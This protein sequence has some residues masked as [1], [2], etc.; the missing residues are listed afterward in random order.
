MYFVPEVMLVAPVN[1]LGF[2]AKLCRSAVKGREERDAR[3]DCSTACT[4]GDHTP[5]LYKLRDLDDRAADT[6]MFEL[7]AEIGSL[8]QFVRKIVSVAPRQSCHT[9]LEP[10]SLAGV[11]GDIRHAPPITRLGEPKRR[12]G[13]PS[14]HPAGDL[15]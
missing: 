2:V 12:S 10:V 13:A 11:L 6:T 5:Y 7:D 9:G 4:R 15:L 14:A 8:V 3:R 1:L